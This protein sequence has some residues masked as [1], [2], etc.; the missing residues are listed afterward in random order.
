MSNVSPR[1][2]VGQLIKGGGKS[3]L[4]KVAS[5]GLAYLTLIVIAR[6]TSAEQYG[7]FAVAFSVAVSVS[8]VSAI[9]Q[10][11]AL[12][13][14]WPQWMSQNKPLKARAVLKLSMIVAATGLSI[15]VVFMLLG[16]ALD[17]I[18]DVPWSLGLAGA[19]ALLG[20]A[21]GWA[22]ISAAGLRAQEYIVRAQAP[23]DIGWRVLVC[24]TFGVAAIAGMSFDAETIVLTLAGFLV[25][26]VLPQAVALIRSVK[27]ASLNNLLDEDQKAF[28][29]FTLN[30]WALNSLGTARNYAGVIIISTFLG[31]VAAG[32]YFVADRT[33]NLLSF[34]L[35]AVNMVTAP[36]IS[37]YHHSDRPE[38]VQLIVAL[39]G[40]VGGL[41]ALSGLL[42]LAI[43]GAKIL[44]LFD[45]SYV[46]YMPVL[47]ILAF[48]QF[49]R[50][51]LGP[52]GLL[53]MMSGH[54]RINLILLVTIGPASIVLQVVG[55]LYFGPIGVA[56]A[57][58]GG[59]VC[60]RSASALYAW[61]VIGIDSTGISLVVQSLQSLRNR[62][63]VARET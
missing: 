51:A 4:I 33:A 49:V 40:I 5:A 58:A 44:A 55:G 19:T 18:V 56:M 22:N 53:L 7:I 2:V 61:R 3:I 47:F 63:R 37:K 11:N 54:E 46:R 50:T 21:M 26:M 31:P 12:L 36:L 30:S 39:S 60:M 29:R 20:F 34:F 24:L 15:T 35:M 52:S 32:A 23:R 10:S 42:F 1:D 8:V 13:R 28:R 25:V 59:I 17:L 16:G 41:S 6:V 14:F 57:T 45:P 27:G 62:R 48:G 43:F 9:G 38:M